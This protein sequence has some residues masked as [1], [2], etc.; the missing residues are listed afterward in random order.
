MSDYREQA[1]RCP[2]CSSTLD[3]RQA[4]EATIDVCGHCRGIF[5]D[6]HDGDP[7]ELVRGLVT[8]LSALPVGD[9][10][11]KLPGACPRCAVP[12][13]V[14]LFEERGPWLQRCE[15]CHGIFLDVVAAEVLASTSSPDSL[16]PDER[17]P[18]SRIG[19]A[20]RTFLFGGPEKIE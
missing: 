18:I 1:L 6:W 8:P 5:L 7:R 20:M 4:G 3:A 13:H 11:P 2:S 14:E 10:P 15:G 9:A 16:P 12:F 19:D 17:G